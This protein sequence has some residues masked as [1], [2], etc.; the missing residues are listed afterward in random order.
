MILL[1]SA[2]ITCTCR[3]ISLNWL[4][5]IGQYIVCSGCIGQY[6]QYCVF[7]FGKSLS[8]IFSYYK[9]GVLLGGGQQAYC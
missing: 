7:R 2:V 9:G 4:G 6:I 3:T 5:C 8:H 1:H